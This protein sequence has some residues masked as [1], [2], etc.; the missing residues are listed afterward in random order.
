MP[1]CVTH[2]HARAH[3]SCAVRVC[4]CTLRTGAA[5]NLRPTHALHTHDI[6]TINPSSPT[7]H[8]AHPRTPLALTCF[9]FWRPPRHTHNHTHTQTKRTRNAHRRCWTVGP[10][11]PLSRAPIPQSCAAF[12]MRL[13]HIGSKRA[14]MCECGA[15]VHA[16][17]CVCLLALNVIE[18]T[19][20]GRNRVIEPT[21]VHRN[22]HTPA[23]RTYRA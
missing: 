11:Q 13:L 12:L 6:I 15:C 23:K 22:T 4:V 19:A 16:C 7:K 18:F 14:R 5:D 9:P 10:R 20:G 2:A 3:G 1:V 8:A 21:Q 17:V